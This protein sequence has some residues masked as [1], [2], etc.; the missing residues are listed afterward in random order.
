M[1][2]GNKNNFH[3]YNIFD[4]GKKYRGELAG[5]N[6]GM[7]SAKYAADPASNLVEGDALHVKERERNGPA[8]GRTH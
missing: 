5:W 2:V 7:P 6:T 3:L 4:G 1:I 8:F